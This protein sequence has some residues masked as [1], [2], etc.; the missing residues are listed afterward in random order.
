MD[1]IFWKPAAQSSHHTTWDRQSVIDVIVDAPETTTASFAFWPFHPLVDVII[2][3][4][5]F[6]IM[7]VVTLGETV[8]VPPAY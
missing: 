5:E 8:T 4:A 6:I 3:P 7:Y 2:A 1:V